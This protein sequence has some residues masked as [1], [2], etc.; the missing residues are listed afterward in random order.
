METPRPTALH[1][2]I[3]GSRPQPS[4]ID[5]YADCGRWNCLGLRPTSLR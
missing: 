2:K 1:P 4:R 3:C 5:A